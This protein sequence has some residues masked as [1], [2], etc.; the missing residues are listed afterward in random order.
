MLGLSSNSF[1][2]VASAYGALMPLTKSCKDRTWNVIWKLKIPQKIRHFIWLVY[3]G[4]ILT[5]KEREMMG[6]TLD[7]T[8]RC[9]G[10][11]VEDLNHIFIKCSKA[12]PFGGESQP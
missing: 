11:E 6:F 1:F 3:H 4:R 8:C 12:L 9:C 5:N 7:P 10:P 2:L